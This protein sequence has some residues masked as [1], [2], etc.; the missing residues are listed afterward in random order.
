MKQD[1][2]QL[3]ANWLQSEYGEEFSGVLSV[4]QGSELIL[5]QAVGYRNRAERLPNLPNT[6]FALASGT[7]LFTALAVCNLLKQG[8]L[9][10]TDTLGSILPADLG[11]IDPGITI[12]QLLTHT[13]GIGD[14]IDED[15]DTD[16]QLDHLYRTYPSYLWTSMDYYLQMMTSLPPKFEKGTEVSYSNTGYIMLGLVIEAVSGTSYQQFVTKHIIKALNLTHT[17]FYSLD[18]LP[19]NTALGYLQDDETGAWKTNMFSVPIIGGSDGGIFS[20]AA[21]LTVLWNAIV[22]GELLGEAVTEQLLTP[23]AVAY[24]E[25]DLHYGLGVYVKQ[26]A[27]KPYYYTAGYDAGVHVQ[28]AYF[29]EQQLSVC[30]LGNVM[31]FDPYALM[32]N[33]RAYLN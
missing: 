6:A 24:A 14:Y 18:A 30:V 22:S 16:A 21:D 7:K 13:S 5:A 2:Q 27:G 1:L 25:Y 17:G 28:S 29:P 19:A 12:G 9:N 20:S 15:Q 8:K 10:L 32:A 3:F 4:Y 33:V 26:G 31:D 23:H 11:T